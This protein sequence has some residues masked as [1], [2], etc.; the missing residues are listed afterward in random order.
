MKSSSE[1]PRR[2][3]SYAGKRP[4][5]RS[6]LSS[7]GQP[8][9]SRSS[10]SGHSAASRQA[11]RPTSLRLDRPRLPPRRLVQNGFPQLLAG[12][13]PSGSL[14]RFEV[15]APRWLVRQGPC[16]HA[17]E[18]NGLVNIGLREF[19]V[20]F[21]EPISHGVDQ[22]VP[23]RLFHAGACVFEVEMD[24]VSRIMLRTK[25]AFIGLLPRLEASFRRADIVGPPEPRLDAIADMEEETFHI[26]SPLRDCGHP[27]RCFALERPHN[28]CIGNSSL[29]VCHTPVVTA[30]TVQTPRDP[31]LELGS[32]RTRR[33]SQ[34]G[35][36][37]HEVWLSIEKHY[38]GGWE[39]F[40]VDHA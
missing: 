12:E 38:P 13:R 40:E 5:S 28:R 8:R 35:C 22:A 31:R 27:G 21:R 6:A 18:Q 30:G 4:P 24:P 36:R 11:R 9:E 37:E 20:S 10:S 26:R 19:S 15:T 2:K 23:A 14:R 34:R 16:L 1:R 17:I 3:E 33:L 7:D 32:S 25:N 39:Q 29:L